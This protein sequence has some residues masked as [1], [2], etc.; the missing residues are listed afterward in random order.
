MIDINVPLHQLGENSLIYA[1]IGFG[2]ILFTTMGSMLL[3]CVLKKSKNNQQMKKHQDEIKKVTE[4]V[5]QDTI[6]SQNLVIA[7]LALAKALEEKKVTVKN[8]EPM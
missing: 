8:V 5:I 2:G 4:K 1:V 3:R 7:D 6:K